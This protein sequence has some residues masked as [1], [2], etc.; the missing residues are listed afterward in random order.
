MSK[1]KLSEETIKQIKRDRDLIVKS[2][3]IVKK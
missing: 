1:E 2:N 3:Q